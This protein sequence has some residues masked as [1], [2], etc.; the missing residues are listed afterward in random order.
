MLLQQV[1]WVKQ[2][3]SLRTTSNIDT[4]CDTSHNAVIFRSNDTSHNWA[5]IVLLNTIGGA[6]VTELNH[7]HDLVTKELKRRN[8]TGYRLAMESGIPI[9]T[10]RS[11][12]NKKTE[13]KFNTIIGICKTLDINCGALTNAKYE[14]VDFTMLSGEQMNLIET[15]RV[16][17]SDVVNALS[18]ITNQLMLAQG[19]R[20]TFKQES[21]K[22]PVKKNNKK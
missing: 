22:K 14:V 8:W 6:F 4:L 19:N 10:V 20:I 15:V 18:T 21:K 5:I 9:S 11:F 7:F 1:K 17:D 2:K 3:K 16:L 12:L 13:I